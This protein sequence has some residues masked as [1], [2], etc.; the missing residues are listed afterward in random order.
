MAQ[1]EFELD[2][3]DDLL[4]QVSPNNDSL[5]NHAFIASNSD[6]DTLIY[7]E[8][9]MAT[10]KQEFYNAMENEITEL[11][12][13]NT[14]KIVPCSQA[15]IQQKKILPGTWTF[16]NKRYPDGHMQTYKA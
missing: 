2:A 15:T 10:Y 1:K 7:H 4:Q 14:L 9:M 6:L 8:A 5:T 13:Q 3:T 16:K 12:K 11:E